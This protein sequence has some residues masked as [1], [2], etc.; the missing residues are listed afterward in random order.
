MEVASLLIH[1]FLDACPI[2]QYEVSV[3]LNKITNDDVGFVAV[4]ACVYNLKVILACT[5]TGTHELGVKMV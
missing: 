4:G 1:N 2:S 3:N 5:W